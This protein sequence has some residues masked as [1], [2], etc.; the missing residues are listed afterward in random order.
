MRAILQIRCASTP[1]ACA[2]RHAVK[3]STLLRKY[4]ETSCRHRG[5]RDPRR[6]KSERLA[7]VDSAPPLRVALVL[8]E[9]HPWADSRFP[10]LPKPLSLCTAPC[11]GAVAGS[12]V[13]GRCGAVS[14][15]GGAIFCG[16]T[17]PAA[18][19]ADRVAAATPQTRCVHASSSQRPLYGCPAASFPADAESGTHNALGC[20]AASCTWRLRMPILWRT[21]KC[22]L[23]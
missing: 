4:A 2:T 18:H 8:G 23:P 13:A 7:R 14:H 10:C 1:K 12:I 11:S 21:R 5:P 19:G 17:E 3:S 20:G 22:T 6:Q 9:A 16:G 15:V